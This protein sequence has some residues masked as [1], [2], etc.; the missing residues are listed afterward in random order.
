ML[1]GDL[2]KLINF[3][4]Y[5]TNIKY[6]IVLQM[7]LLEIAVIVLGLAGLTSP[8]VTQT[9]TTSDYRE[10]MTGVLEGLFQTNGGRPVTR[11]QRQRLGQEPASS[12]PSTDDEEPFHGYGQPTTLPTTARAPTTVPTVPTTAMALVT[13]PPSAKSLSPMSAESLSTTARP[14]CIDQGNGCMRIKDFLNNILQH[15]SLF[16]SIISNNNVA[17]SDNF[18]LLDNRLIYNSGDEVKLSFSEANH[19]CNRANAFLFEVKTI[20]DVDFLDQALE[21]NTLKQIWV[22]LEAS[23]GRDEKYKNYKLKY[24]SN[25]EPLSFLKGRKLVFPTIKPDDCMVFKLKPEPTKFAKFACSTARPFICQIPV[26]TELLISKIFSAFKEPILQVA[27]SVINKFMTSHLQDCFCPFSKNDV[28]TRLKQLFPQQ[29]QAT[30]KATND[31]QLDHDSEQN[32]ATNVFSLPARFFDITLV[33]VILAT[34]AIFSACMACYN[35]CKC[36]PRCYT[37]TKPTANNPTETETD[38][39]LDNLDTISLPTNFDK[40]RSV[41]FK[42]PLKSSRR[43]GLST[44]NDN[45]STTSSTSTIGSPSKV[46]FPIRHRK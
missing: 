2:E 1:H 21:K 9:P 34:I 27:K 7:K 44:E 3:R 10:R 39:Q 26:T 16:R 18:V 43:P 14:T 33:D 40:R 31:Q 45:I 30:L 36:A 6:P 46:H 5:D 24:P 41:S 20:Q 4:R 15:F 25:A 35:F 29:K 23:P 11:P 13:T 32:S 8:R 17:I 42:V 28:N 12:E 22:N 19:L 37:P 38:I